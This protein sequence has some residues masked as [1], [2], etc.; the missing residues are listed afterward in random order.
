MSIPVRIKYV[1]AHRVIS[2]EERFEESRVPVGPPPS[3]E[4]AA[5]RQ[6]EV[7]KRSLGWFVRLE[8]SSAI[9]PFPDDPGFKAGDVLR[10]T[11]EKA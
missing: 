1:C 8:G 10:A 3:A 11:W 5:N 2:C 7:R 4:S 6:Y 9:G